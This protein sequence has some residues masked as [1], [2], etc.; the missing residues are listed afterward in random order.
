MQN[1]PQRTHYRRQRFH[2]LEQAA[3]AVVQAEVEI[4]GP[5][6]A[7]QVPEGLPYRVRG[8]GELVLGGKAV[9]LRQHPPVGIEMTGGQSVA[10]RKWGSNG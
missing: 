3:H 9:A 10:G 6:E 5:R 2:I 4:A 7:V 8:R 1:A